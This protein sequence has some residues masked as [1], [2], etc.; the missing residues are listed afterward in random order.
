MN[1]EMTRDAY[2]DIRQQVGGRPAESGGILL[3]S[4]KDYKVVRFIFD[5]SGSRS[6]GG[7]DP[8][9]A[10]LNHQVKAAWEQEGLE[11]LG[12]VHSHPPG[13]T[14]LSGDFGNN[15]GDLGYLK[16]IFEA[17]PSLKH[18]LVPLAFTVPDTGRFALIP[19]IAKRGQVEDYRQVALIVDGKS[20]VPA[21]KRERISWIQLPAFGARRRRAIP[22]PV[23]TT[24][25]QPEGPPMDPKRLNGA[26][27]VARMGQTHVVCIGV[28]GA[29]GLVEDL[30]R[31]GLGALTVMDFDTVDASNLC[32]QG[33]ERGDIGLHKVDALGERVRRINP[34]LRYTGLKQDFLAL[35]DREV[36]ALLG[37]ADLLLMMT[38]DFHAQARGNKVALR[39][40]TPALFAMVYEKARAAEA[41]FVIP[42]VTP[43][44]HRCAVSDRYRAYL[45]EA[46]ENDVES[47]GSTVF[48]TRYL[49]ACLGLLALAIL[50][51]DSDGLELGGWFPKQWDRNLLQVRMS[52]RYGVDREGSLFHRL[53]AENP[54]VFVFDSVWQRIEPEA[55]P[56]YAQACPDCGGVGHLEPAQVSAEPDQEE[57]P[58][59]VPQDQEPCCEDAAEPLSEERQA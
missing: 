18:F 33:F 27:D 56:K 37:D 9:V 6:S 51:R 26:V 40:G 59:L 41:T 25:T 8:D 4:R 48:H 46:Y 17:M 19:Y 13:V 44:C 16:A 42:G 12:F 21:P 31:S 30:V 47:T 5:P 22:V 28:G 7:Y 36:D 11:L 24:P 49:N 3:G 38:D 43:G 57:L 58:A 14:R 29:N 23:P 20:Y 50:H 2:E 45:E 53:G 32:T 52:P 35:E 55:P 34:D 10:Y 1:L 39:N 15:T 54:R